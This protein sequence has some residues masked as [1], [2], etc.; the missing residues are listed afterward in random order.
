MV[1]GQPCGYRDDALYFLDEL[2]AEAFM[3]RD[4]VAMLPNQ[5]ATNRALHAIRQDGAL[6]RALFRHLNPHHQALLTG[7]EGREYMLCVYDT[8]LSP[9]DEAF[10]HF[11]ARLWYENGVLRW[12]SLSETVAFEEDANGLPEGHR[13]DIRGVERTVRL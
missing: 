6:N 5:P 2:I 10:T 8:R 1:R 12:R 4:P 13:Y 3:H 9:D 7:T 11:K